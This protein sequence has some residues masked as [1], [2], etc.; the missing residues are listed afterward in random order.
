MTRRAFFA[1]AL[2][3]PLARADT[4]E[5]CPVEIFVNSGP[6]LEITV[7]HM[8]KGQIESV[9]AESWMPHGKVAEFR[10][11]LAK[12]KEISLTLTSR[13]R[14]PKPAQ[15]LRQGLEWKQGTRVDLP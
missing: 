14:I 9:I 5:D 11:L 4:K 3:A 6:S 7:P 8:D 15:G 1:A 12:S 10:R 2:G 13:C